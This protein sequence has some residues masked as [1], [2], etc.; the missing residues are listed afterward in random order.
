MNEQYIKKTLAIT[1]LIAMAK[2]PNVNMEEL[3]TTAYQRGFIDGKDYT[4]LKAIEAI[5][6]EK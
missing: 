1:D 3:F 5:E 4:K 6:Q 2:F